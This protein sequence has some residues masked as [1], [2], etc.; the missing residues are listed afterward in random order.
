[1]NERNFSSEMKSFVI[2]LLSGEGQ[3]IV[4]EKGFIPLNLLED[5]KQTLREHGTGGKPHI[6]IPGD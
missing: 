4:E 1:M 5:I 3:K 6:R 2:Y